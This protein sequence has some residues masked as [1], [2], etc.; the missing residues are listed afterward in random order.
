ML[1]GSSPP[2]DARPRCFQDDA[3]RLPLLPCS[4]TTIRARD[5]CHI[6]TGRRRTASQLPA[7]CNPFMA[8]SGGELPSGS[9]LQSLLHPPR[10]AATSGAPIAHA[11]GRLSNPAT[12]TA[13]YKVN[14]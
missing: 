7:F 11:T 10:W 5:P 8:A 1:S 4:D 3:H 13:I 14:I 12:S 2:R 9:L 6:V